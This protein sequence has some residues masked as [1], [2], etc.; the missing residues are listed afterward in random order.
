VLVARIPDQVI[1]NGVAILLVGWSGAAYYDMWSRLDIQTRPGARG[2]AEFILKS[3]ASD[4]PVVVSSSLIYY[5]M[6]YHLRGE[7]DCRLL[8]SETLAHN[9]GGPFS[10]PEDFITADEISGIAV[11]RAWVVTGGWQDRPLSVPAH[12]KLIGSKQFREV[13]AFQ[14]QI[15][16][17]EYAVLS[18]RQESRA[19]K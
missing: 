18:N 7:M 6:L 3:A 13:F 14:R 15:S 19:D 16:V 2:A 8:Q 12:W 4:D 5:P 10:K 17:D 1:R 11:G 9:I